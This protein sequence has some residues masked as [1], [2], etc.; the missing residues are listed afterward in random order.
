MSA[1]RL[2]VID[3]KG[4]YRRNPEGIISVFDRLVINLKVLLN[5]IPDPSIKAKLNYLTTG[6]SLLAEEYGENPEEVKQD[7]ENY[8]IEVTQ[9]Q[10]YDKSEE[11]QNLKGAMTGHMT[12]ASDWAYTP[13]SHKG[14]HKVDPHLGIKHMEAIG[15]VEKKQQDI[16]LT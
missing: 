14:E 7:M 11:K 9:S 12:H 1:Y 15:S 16:V 4:N 10:V 2:G 6:I 8:L 5:K 13:Y 3:E